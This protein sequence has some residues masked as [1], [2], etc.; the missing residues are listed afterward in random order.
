MLTTAR[1]RA[2]V[3]PAGLGW[4]SALKTTDIRKLLKK[5]RGE[6]RALLRLGE[7]QPDAVAEITS[8][9]FPGERL[10]VCFNPRQREER[11]R[12]REALLGATEAILDE[13]PASSASRSQSYAAASGSTSGSAAK[14]TG[15]GSRST[16]RSSSPTTISPGRAIRRRSPPRHNWTASTSCVPASV[17]TQSMHTKPSRRT[18]PCHE[19][20]APSETS[21]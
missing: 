5:P 18:S 13:L 8:P 10:L 12:K 15:A 1:L 16:S 2:T 14:P 4:I 17:P 9:D 3:E 6:E 21:R 20:S 11:A 7:L 19:L